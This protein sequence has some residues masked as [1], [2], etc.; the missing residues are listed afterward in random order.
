M[1]SPEGL[2]LLELNKNGPD[3]H[4]KRSSKA[5][6]DFVRSRPDCPLPT[7]PRPPSKEVD[8]AFDNEFE[9]AKAP[10]LC[11][12]S[13]V[14]HASTPT[15]SRSVVHEPNSDEDDPST[16]T[17]PDPLSA[18]TSSPVAACD[19][20]TVE[21]ALPSID[22]TVEA[23]AVSTS[24]SIDDPNISTPFVEKKE[25][26]PPDVTVLHAE[27]E[28]TLS[29]DD[30]DLESITSTTFGVDPDPPPPNGSPY[31]IETDHSALLSLFR[32]GDSTRR[33]ARYVYGLQHPDVTLVHTP[34][35]HQAAADALSRCFCTGPPS[36][37]PFPKIYVGTNAHPHPV[38]GDPT[39]EDSEAFLAEMKSK[40]FHVY[41]SDRRTGHY[42]VMTL[43]K[44]KFQADYVV[45]GFDMNKSYIPPDDYPN[46]DEGFGT[47]L[48][49]EEDRLGPFAEEG[50]VLT[51]K[52]PR[53]MVLNL[54]VPNE[55][56]RLLVMG[57][58]NVP[59]KPIDRITPEEYVRLSK[60]K[61][62]PPKWLHVPPLETDWFT[63][64]L[65][66]GLIDTF[67]SCHPNNPG[68]TW[69]DPY[70]RDNAAVWRVDYILLDDRI[71][72]AYTTEIEA[73]ASD[74][75]MV[76]LKFLPGS[77]GPATDTNVFAVQTRR[78]KKDEDPDP[79]PPKDDSSDGPARGRPR[80]SPRHA[81]PPEKAPVTKGPVDDA[82]PVDDSDDDEVEDTLLANEP[83]PPQVE[84]GLTRETRTL[85]T[86]R[87]DKFK[88]SGYAL[89]GRTSARVAELQLLD[90]DF[91]DIIVYKESGVMPDD[92][93][94]SREEFLK[95]CDP[96]HYNRKSKLLYHI[97]HISEKILRRGGP[98]LAL[99]VPDGLR[100]EVLNSVKDKKPAEYSKRQRFLQT[101]NK[102]ALTKTRVKPIFTTMDGNP[103][104]SDS[105]DDDEESL[106]EG[107][108]P[109]P[110]EAALPI[111]DVQ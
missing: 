35:R 89:L 13:Q 7:T 105:D 97:T 73:T 92:V 11:Q 104:E 84:K 111:D 25:E 19:N 86:F 3:I 68:F 17:S 22:D 61:C 26:T 95:Q 67:R 87:T 64:Y 9:S 58:F 103:P 24:P 45:E 110:L 15:P 56:Y 60:T 32:K 52:L 18:V 85:A 57:D 98:V 40:D 102:K 42:G 5:D 100:R 90:P 27:L 82:P 81:A 10:F 50:R 65:N 4:Y 101:S 33:F 70:L 91:K 34:G 78:R 41:S 30:G 72:K 28:E 71:K 6:R 99:C 62:T 8:D 46:D 43:V 74:H 47:R 39:V 51:V 88:A 106:H 96:Y 79:T 48:P 53:Y 21:A 1:I 44:K 38:P 54:Y 83:T 63:T 29:D 23:A 76:K 109:I 80:R 69:K 55:G 108:V 59:H 107:E 66:I 36:P 20:V 2:R 14:A 37:L 93:I 75:C 77:A 94:D 16:T 31:T 49:D 12:P